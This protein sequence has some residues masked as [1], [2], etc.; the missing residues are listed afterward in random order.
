MA[1]RRG[2]PEDRL[3]RLGEELERANR[4][5]FGVYGSRYE[6]ALYGTTK[7]QYEEPTYDD[8]STEAE[9]EAKKAAS[10]KRI[11]E[12]LDELDMNEDTFDDLSVSKSSRVQHI[13]FKPDVDVLEVLERAAEKGVSNIALKEITGTIE[14]KWVN[15]KS[16]WGYREVTLKDFI[17]FKDVDKGRGGGSFGKYVNEVMNNF[18]ERGP[19]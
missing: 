18:T 8:S 6:S 9:E 5:D 1:R 2:I 10:Q 16:D 13:S 19:L 4:G 15:G 7:P 3:R 11:A 12:L 17:N 14:V